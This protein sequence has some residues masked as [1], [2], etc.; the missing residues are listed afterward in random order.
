MLH[1][2]GFDHGE[3]LLII[4]FELRASVFILIVNNGQLPGKD[5]D[6]SS[7]KDVFDRQIRDFGS[8]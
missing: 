6:H 1:S 2:V 8:F 5:G 7:N 4:N 3:G